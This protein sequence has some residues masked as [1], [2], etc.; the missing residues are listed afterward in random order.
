MKSFLI[1]HRLSA[2]QLQLQTTLPWRHFSPC[3][4]PSRSWK[5][6]EAWASLLRE[7]W[8]SLAPSAV[9][10]GNRTHRTARNSHSGGVIWPGCQSEPCVRAC[11]RAHV[12][13]QVEFPGLDVMRT[14]LHTDCV[15]NS[16]PSLS[17]LGICTRNAEYSLSRVSLSVLAPLSQHSQ[18]FRVLHLRSE[19]LS[20]KQPQRACS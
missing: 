13:M 15:C 14:L 17:G 11:V 12:P 16:A 4:P 18:S 8:M 6:E 20:Q 9:P 3:L 1:I 5:E 7:R 2:L 10:W 19:N